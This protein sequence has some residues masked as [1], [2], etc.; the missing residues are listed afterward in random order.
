MRPI[1]QLR[2]LI[3]EDSELD[4][5]IVERQLTQETLAIFEIQIADNIL[6]AVQAIETKNIDCVLLDL[7][8]PDSSGLETFY[9][10]HKATHDIP[11]VILS[12]LDD[13]VAAITAVQQGAQDYLV[14]GEMNGRLLAKSILHAIER[15]KLFVEKTLLIKKLEDALR[16]INTLEGILPVC[17]WC[18][19][20]RDNEGN[21]DLFEEYLIKHSKA[22]V[23]HGIC[24]DCMKSF[25]EQKSR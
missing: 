10:L 25:S 2:I 1:E 11:V 13:E 22:D 16:R 17:S 12:G 14:K 3:V 5:K 9:R 8:L 4:A 23:S 20:I 21:W 19:R 15:K 18:K 7:G 24:P 6:S